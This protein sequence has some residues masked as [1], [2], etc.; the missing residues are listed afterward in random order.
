M[1]N[2]KKFTTNILE[3]TLRFIKYSY[4]IYII[5]CCMKSLSINSL[6]IVLLFTLALGVM[7]FQ[8]P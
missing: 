3:A 1:M 4:S 2:F 5:N 8:V 7:N 6:V